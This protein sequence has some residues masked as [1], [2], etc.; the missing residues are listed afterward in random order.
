M[1][2]SNSRQGKLVEICWCVCKIIEKSEM[3]AKDFIQQRY[4]E[5]MFTSL[6]LGWGSLDSWGDRAQQLP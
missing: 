1:Y 3:S 4:Y 2:S 6:F 5:S